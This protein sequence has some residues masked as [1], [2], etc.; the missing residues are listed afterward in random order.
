MN[1]VVSEGS[2]PFPRV[3]AEPALITARIGM[4]EVLASSMT[5]KR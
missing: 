3:V 4:D 2:S 1:G 5:M